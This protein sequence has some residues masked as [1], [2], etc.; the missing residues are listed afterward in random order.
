M[1]SPPSRM[2]RQP[3]PA[4]QEPA[5]A[6]HRISELCRI[7]AAA[8]AEVTDHA[9]QWNRDGLDEVWDN[10]LS[11]DA[12]A[13]ARAEIRAIGRQL[14]QEGGLGRMVAACDLVRSLAP[15]TNPGGV[16]L[17]LWAGIGEWDLNGGLNDL[18]RR[19]AKGRR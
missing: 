1:S 6:A 14:D 15:S 13:Q 3:L 12:S 11:A 10:N 2:T 17:L 19:A 4:G 18:R 16:V 9:L 7:S 8:T 5:H